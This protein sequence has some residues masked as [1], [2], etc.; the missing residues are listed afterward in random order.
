[1]ALLKDG[2]QIA[3]TW[4]HAGDE[5]PLQ[6]D[7]PAIVSLTRWNAEREDIIRSGMEVG[8]RLTSAE[9]PDDLIADL[10]HLDVVVLEFPV[11][12]D[13]RAYSY[14][15]LLR[16]RHDYQGELRASGNVLRDQFLFMHR[17]GIDSFE[18]EKPGDVDGFLEAMNEVDLF[19][20][21]ASDGAMTVFDRRRA[22]MAAA[23]AAE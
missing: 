17:C 14:A 9:R 10:A 1:M 23:A 21:P 4:H 3:D 20:Q 6:P 12:T 16:D 7:I 8:V 22:I 19:Y 5:D 18:V 2:K 15:R 11:Y 13:G